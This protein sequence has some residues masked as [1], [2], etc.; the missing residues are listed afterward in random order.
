MSTV[1]VIEDDAD[2]LSMMET[3]LGR[4]GWSVLKA[5]G[6]QEGLRLARE[7]SP[8]IVLCDVT[9]PDLDGF[10]LAR[11]LS[12][13][14]PRPPVVFISGNRRQAEDIV[15]GLEGGGHGYILKPVDL[16]I[17]HAKLEAVLRAVKGG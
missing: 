6:G 17:I 15:R 13:E 16:R 9:L 8:D 4:R 11:R 14:G 7:A 12:A 2:L 10:E 3:F 1:L 5:S